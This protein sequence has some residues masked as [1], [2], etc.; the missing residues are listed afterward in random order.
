MIATSLWSAYSMVRGSWITK[1]LSIAL[2]GITAY[3]THN[4]FIKR[5][6]VKA[7]ISDSKKEGRKKNAKAKKIRAATAKPGAAARL[8]KFDCHDC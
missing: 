8:L 7:F 6:A 5:Q 2:V 3:W 4:T 1:W